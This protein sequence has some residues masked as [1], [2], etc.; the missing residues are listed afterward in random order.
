MAAVPVARER[1]DRGR[2]L[3][4]REARGR[5][6]QVGN[7]AG[8]GR[9]RPDGR[10]PGE[11]DEDSDKDSK[12]EARSAADAWTPGRCGRLEAGGRDRTRTMPH[13][14]W[15]LLSAARLA[16]GAPWHC[17]PAS[18]RVCGFE[19]AGAAICRQ[20]WMFRNASEGYPEEAPGH[21][22]ALVPAASAVFERAPCTDRTGPP[23]NGVRG[24]SRGPSGL[25]SSP[26]CPV[27]RRTSTP[28]SWGVQHR[29]RRLESGAW[30]GPD[31]AG[32]GPAGHLPEPP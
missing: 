2:I 12:L 6:P 8:D 4:Q 31:A 16:Q 29:D 9:A 13:H 23:Q 1:T 25:G 15:A 30:Y 26:H 10:Q 24:L 14:R 5:D 22:R 21:R 27:S 28:A 19:E 17:D 11:P 18:R 32:R 3:E 7:L 20:P